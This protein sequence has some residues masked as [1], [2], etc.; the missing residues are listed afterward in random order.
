[1]TLRDIAMDMQKRVIVMMNRT[2]DAI[3]GDALQCVEECGGRTPIPRAEVIEWVC[4]ADRMDMYGGDKEAYTFWK[5]L[6]RK[7][8]DALAKKAFPFGRYGW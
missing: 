2:W 4:D 6:P 5:T 7:V 1:M 3:G 8:Q